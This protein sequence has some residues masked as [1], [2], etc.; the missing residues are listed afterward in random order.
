M[1]KKRSLGGMLILA[2]TMIFFYL[3]IL[4][5]IVFSFNGSRSLTHFDGFSLQ[6]YEKMFSD[7]TMMEAVGYTILVAVLSTIVS[8]LPAHWPPS[9]SP[10]PDGYCAMWWSR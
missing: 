3:P 4:Y 5:I 6:W 8:T 2:L 10:D 1:E 9:A 7:R